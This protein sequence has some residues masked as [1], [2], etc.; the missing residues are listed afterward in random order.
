[1]F[2]HLKPSISSGL[3]TSSTTVPLKNSPL[4]S[5]PLPPPSPFLPEAP[6]S[7]MCQPTAHTLLRGNSFGQ[8]FHLPLLLEFL[9]SLFGLFIPPP[10]KVLSTKLILPMIVTVPGRGQVALGKYRHFPDFSLKKTPPPLHFSSS[11]DRLL[12]RRRY[13]RSI[14]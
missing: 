13:G 8:V 3:F 5:P 1:M 2:S 9:P 11:P 14:S 7:L 6:L 10:S 12:G 4:I